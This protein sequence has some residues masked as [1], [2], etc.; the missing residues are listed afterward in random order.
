MRTLSTQFLKFQKK[1]AKKNTLK[2]MNKVSL[3][4]RDL[5]EHD[6]SEQRKM[7]K[8]Q[9]LICWVLFFIFEVLCST[10]LLCKHAV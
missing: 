7:W 1:F 8:A 6:Y 2:I 4:W 9:E 10:G 3:K 5:L